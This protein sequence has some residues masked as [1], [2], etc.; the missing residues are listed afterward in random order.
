MVGPTK[1]CPR[2]PVPFI[3]TVVC[4]ATFELAAHLFFLQLTC[5]ILIRVLVRNRPSHQMNLEDFQGVP[6]REWIAQ[7]ATRREIKRRFQS[8]LL[9]FQVRLFHSLSTTRGGLRLKEGSSASTLT[10]TSCMV[11]QYMYTRIY[12][13]CLMPKEDPR[14]IVI[15]ERRPEVPP[16]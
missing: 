11:G 2:Q 6:L 8:F 9:T 3:L 15:S 10:L 5:A 12:A 7:D 14:T 4:S 1:R 13:P 16:P